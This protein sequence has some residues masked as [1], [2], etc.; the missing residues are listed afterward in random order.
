MTRQL[1]FQCSLQ[2]MKY[3]WHTAKTDYWTR[4]QEC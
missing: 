3:P 1:Q 2:S 4:C